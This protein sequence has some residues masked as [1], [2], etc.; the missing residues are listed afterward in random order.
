MMAI[1][2]KVPNIKNNPVPRTAF[3]KYRKVYPVK[4]ISAK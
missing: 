4:S 3:L 1:K 2:S